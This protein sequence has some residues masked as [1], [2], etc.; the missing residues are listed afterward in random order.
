MQT[1]I[2]NV[3]EVARLREQIETQLVAM[4]RGLSGLASGT[5]RHAFINARM[6][7]LG[8]CQA[9]LAGQLGEEDAAL[10]VYG[11]YNE[12]MDAPDVRR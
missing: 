5:A 12:V 8:T 9:S 3:S 6:E 2:H 11:I 10:V 1:S 4:R 7:H